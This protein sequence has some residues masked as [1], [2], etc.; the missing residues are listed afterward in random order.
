[1]KAAVLTSSGFQ[2]NDENIPEC[3]AD[4]ILVKSAGCGVCEG[5]VFQYIT[6]MSNPECKQDFIRMGHEGSGVVAEVGGNVQGFAPGD[7]VTALGGDYAEYFLATPENLALVPDGVDVAM[8]LGEPIACCMHAARRFN[9]QMGDRVAIIGSGYMG[10]TCLQ[11]V[12]MQGAAETVVLD[13]LDW[14]LE[15]AKKLDADVTVNSNGQDA[16]ALAEKLG[17]FDVVIEATGVQ[18]AI[19][20]GTLL[21][22]HH[23]TLNLVGYHQ[24]G[25]GMRNID[26]KTWN[27]KALTVINSHVRNRVEKLDAMKAALKLMAGGK[28]DTSALITNYQFADINQ[29][30]QDLKNRKK[31]L[32][33][34]NLLF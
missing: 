2:I 29:A 4:Q 9:V 12:R 23:G 33:K 17:E 31:D 30:F 18:A 11:L 21:L 13:L 16:A 34:A 20:L 22:R 24:S 14:R 28:L 5:D 25:G 6:R 8:A 27:F 19:D 26:M 10:L 7:K 15:T 1:M 3:G 32:Y